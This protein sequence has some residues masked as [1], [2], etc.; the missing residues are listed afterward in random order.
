MVVKTALYLL[1]GSFW[2]L[3][4]FKKNV[5]LLKVSESQRNLFSLVEEN[6][7]EVAVK[8]AVFGSK[9]K[10][11]GQ[12][13]EKFTISQHF[14]TLSKKLMANYFWQF[15]QTLILYIH[16]KFSRRTSLLKISVSIFSEFD[17]HFLLS[18]NN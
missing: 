15:S 3:L 1:G 17:W 6:F 11:W 8:T 12:T 18:R 14:R 7:P 5:H 2:E 9:R 4:F 16:R 10:I 13:L